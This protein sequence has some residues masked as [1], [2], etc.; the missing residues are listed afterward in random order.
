MKKIEQLP[1][2]TLNESIEKRLNELNTYLEKQKYR[3]IKGGQIRISKSHNSEQFYY[4]TN[5]KDK[6]GKY[7]PKEQ[8]SFVKEIAQENYDKNFAKKA[9]EEIV[10]LKQIQHKYS[11][12]NSENYNNTILKERQNLINKATLQD[13]EYAQKWNKI[14][15]NGKGFCD[16]TPFFITENGLKVRSK[17]E[18]I[19]AQT[20]EKA[21]IPFR[22]EYPVKLNKIVYPDFYC[23]NVRTRKEYIWEHIGKL[24]DKEYI[25]KNIIKFREYVKHGYYLGQNLII[26]YETNNFPLDPQ[27]VQKKIETYLF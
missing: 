8:I 25:E 17:S 9:T 19:I 4:V 26:T 20:L 2:S 13:E 16:N 12:K 22:Y 24:D 7:I 14:I 21:G 6:N 15:Y 27:E 10:F 1:P 18:V 3:E 23:L 11:K 5:S